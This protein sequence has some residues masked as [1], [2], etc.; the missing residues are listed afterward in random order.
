MISTSMAL[1]LGELGFGVWRVEAV[2]DEEEWEE[3]LDAEE[4]EV[5]HQGDHMAIDDDDQTVQATALHEV[6]EEDLEPPTKKGIK[7]VAAPDEDERAANPEPVKLAAVVNS[8]S[9]NREPIT[10]P[11]V[12]KKSTPVVIHRMANAEPARTSPEKKALPVIGRR[13][14]KQEP[15][16][17][18]PVE[19]YEEIQG[20]P[21]APSRS[22]RRY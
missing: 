4:D 13:I 15:V 6:D 7:P 5:L 18:P 19:E 2:A 22:S 10:P 17:T 16:S 20:R 11:P 14:P 3:E 8:R 12:D 1:G 9:M 21:A